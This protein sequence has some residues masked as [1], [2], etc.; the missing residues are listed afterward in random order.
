MSIEA[1]KELVCRFFDERWNHGTQ[2]THLH[3]RCCLT[4][5]EGS[6]DQL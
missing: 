5:S 3:R 2:R 4:A 6:R 1:N